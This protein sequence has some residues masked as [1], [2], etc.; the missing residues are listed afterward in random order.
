M[1]VRIWIYVRSPVDVNIA[2]ITSLKRNMQ[3]FCDGRL[4]HVTLPTVPTQYWTWFIAQHRLPV[5]HC[6]QH[7]TITAIQTRKTPTSQQFPATLLRTWVNRKNMRKP[8]I[9]HLCLSTTPWR[10]IGAVW[11]NRHPF[12]TVIIAK[13]ANVRPWLLYYSNQLDS[14]LSVNPEADIDVVETT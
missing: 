1:T 9:H 14:T 2:A 13:G 7:V 12:K 8:K 11:V 6:Q 10:C 4:L 3:F 5:A